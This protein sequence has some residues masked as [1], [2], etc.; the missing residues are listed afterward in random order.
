MDERERLIQ[1]VA[2]AAAGGGSISQIRQN[3]SGLIPD[4]RVNEAIREYERRAGIIRTLTDPVTISDESIPLW[5]AGV[6]SNDRFWPPVRDH[7]RQRRKLPESVIDSV[8]QASDKILSLMQAPGS[9]SINTRGLVLGHVQSGKTT[10]FTAVI[11]KAADRGYRLFIILSGLHNGLRN[12]TQAR[13]QADLVDLNADWLPVTQAG[14]DFG[15][16]A[17]FEASKF[18]AEKRELKVLA[19]V[20]KNKT[21]LTHLRRW[22]QEADR[23]IIDNCPA[24]II[25]DEADQASINSGSDADRTVINSLLRE[26]MA[27]LPRAAYVGYTATPFANV[28]IDPT[29]DDLYP[30]D[31]IVDLDRPANYFG[32]ERIFGRDPL[33]YTDE[34]DRGAS[35]ADMIRIIADTDVPSLRPAGTKDRLTFEPR[36]T[37]SL[38]EAIDYFWL[39]TATRWVRGDSEEHS[40]M[41]VHTTLYARVHQRICAIVSEYRAAILRRLAAA[42]PDLRRSFEQVW[43]IEVER[44]P[45]EECGEQPVRFTDVWDQLP[46]VIDSTVIVEENN[47]SEARLSFDSETGSVQIVVGGNTLS[48]GLTLEGLV[49]S[50]FIRAASAYDTLLQMGRWFGYRDGYSDLPRIWMTGTLRDHFRDLALV[51]EEIRRDIRRYEEQQLRPSQLAVRIRTHPSLAITSAMKMRAAAPVTGSYAGEGPQTIIFHRTDADWLRG[52]LVAASD[53]VRNALGDGAILEHRGVHRLLRGVSAHRVLEF[54]QRYEMHPDNRLI[55]RDLLLEYIREQRAGG[56][57]TDWTVAIPGRRTG[58]DVREIEL[59]LAEPVPTL[60]R[61]RLRDENDARAYVGAIMSPGDRQLDLAPGEKRAREQ[62]LLLLYPIDRVSVPG[63]GAKDRVALNAAEDVVGIGFDFPDVPPEERTPVFVAVQH[64][65]QPGEEV[66][67][68]ETV[69]EEESA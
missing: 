3:L 27:S 44:V 6:Q 25:D 26:I 64:L 46:A 7:F 10:N 60:R 24:L 21:V 68:L 51:E 42:D 41:L 13:L 48:R 52:N 43:A 59:G 58:S 22:L 61:S 38:R 30:K 14:R 65:L 20:K 53:L 63:F 12:Q 1:Q 35:G 39:A 8:E 33:T 19:V 32:P 40:S 45:A 55:R 62:G 4:D 66:E 54:L 16:A 34:E 11:A 2:W 47:Q 67:E 50:Y 5:Y 36:V 28:L 17:G 15:A 18:L 29:L 37:E 49:V 56:R 23:A 57:L 69:P 31:F 9:P